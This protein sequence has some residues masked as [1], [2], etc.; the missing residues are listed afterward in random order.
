[1]FILTVYLNV[2][3]FFLLCEQAKTI[4]T[5]DHTKL[6]SMIKLEEGV[7]STMDLCRYHGNKALESIQ[8]FPSSE[9]RSALENIASTVTKF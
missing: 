9:A 7:T 8:C 6:R 3:P 1:M 4:G 2:F 5:I